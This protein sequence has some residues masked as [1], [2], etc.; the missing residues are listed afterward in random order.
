MGLRA[1][2]DT[3]PQ[4]PEEPVQFSWRGACGNLFSR[5]THSH[6]DETGGERPSTQNEAQRSLRS[7]YVP[8]T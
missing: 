2:R 7:K 1:W 3:Q 4:S 5:T 8:A 6:R